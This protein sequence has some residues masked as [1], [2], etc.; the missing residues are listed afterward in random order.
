MDLIYPRLAAAQWK[1]WGQN[2]VTVVGPEAA[3]LGI[4]ADSWAAAAG[5]LATFADAYD[6]AAEPMTRNRASIQTRKDA[7]E[8][9][10]KAVRPVVAVLQSSPAVSNGLRR[11]LGLRVSEGVRTPVGA[12]A[13][14]PTLTAMLTGPGSLRAIAS[15]PLDPHRRG[16]PRGIRSLAVHEY[17]G[18]TPPGDVGQWALAELAGRTTVDLSYPGLSAM[19]TVWVCACY[20]NSRNE[21]GR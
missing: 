13:V 4:A 17:L 1:P 19:T 18:E 9:F 11:S 3:A 21:R 5:A 7:L 15:D 20:V 6:A 16:K 2:L 8:A 14:A 10:R 12:P